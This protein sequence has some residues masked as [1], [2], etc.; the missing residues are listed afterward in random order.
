MYNHQA[1]RHQRMT[2]DCHYRVIGRIGDDPCVY[3][4]ADASGYDHIPPL[5][6][7]FTMT[8]LEIAYEDLRKYPCCAECNAFLGDSP[9]ISLRDRRQLVRSRLQKKYAHYLRMPSWYESEL[10]EL[11]QEL[12]D[13]VRRHG[14]F[15]DWIKASAHE[16]LKMDKDSP[17]AGKR[18][19]SATGNGKTIIQIEVV[20]AARDP[21]K[22]PQRLMFE[23]RVGGRL[24]CVSDTPFLDTARA[25]LSEGVDPTTPIVLMRNGR[26]CMTSTVGRAGSLTI[27]ESGTPR[28]RKWSPNPWD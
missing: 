26:E 21:G 11:S 2:V 12:A 13:D 3:C 5:S 22:R 17:Q 27:N 24:I 28:F 10:A 7:V 19:P 8:E 25:L 18:I 6:T 14:R 15:A 23:A 4:G 1:L 9:L 16:R 20:S